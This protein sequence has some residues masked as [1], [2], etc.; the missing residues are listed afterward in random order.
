MAK[1]K[2]LVA[3]FVATIA[4]AG[5]AFLFWHGQG[6]I[7]ISWLTLC[8]WLL[9]ILRWRGR[10]KGDDSTANAAQQRIRATFSKILLLMAVGWLGIAGWM[11]YLQMPR[12]IGPF[13]DG[14][15]VGFDASHPNAANWEDPIVRVISKSGQ[16]VVF[17]NFGVYAQPNQKSR[18]LPKLFIGEHVKVIHRDGRYEAVIYNNALQQELGFLGIFMTAAAVCAWAAFA[19]SRK[20]KP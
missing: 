12:I 10:A 9:V 20:P 3:A 17:S 19:L 1:N 18:D 2:L 5:A 7:A 15:V 6:H 16:P 11:T 14:Q 4:F 8:A 13:Y